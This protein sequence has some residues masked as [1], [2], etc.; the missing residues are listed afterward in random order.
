MDEKKKLHAKDTS[1]YGMIFMAIWIAGWTTFTFLTG[2]AIAVSDIITTGIA[3]A[4]SFSPVF[5]SI[6]IDK[7]KEMKIG[8][9]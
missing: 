4:G 2:K 1:Q 3:I 5:I 7:F 9:K 6:I 8:P